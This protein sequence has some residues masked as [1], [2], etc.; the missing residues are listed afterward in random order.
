MYL[1]TLTDP[2]RSN[3]SWRN[4]SNRSSKQ[5]TNSYSSTY[6]AYNIMAYER[7]KWLFFLGVDPNE[8]DVYNVIARAVELLKHFH[9]NINVWHSF[10]APLYLRQRII[11]FGFFS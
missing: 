1:G 3:N 2:K 11:L 10:M 8:H 9:I 7:C 4:K 5:L 6:Q